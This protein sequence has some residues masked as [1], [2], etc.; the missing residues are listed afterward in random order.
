MVTL[1]LAISLIRRRNKRGDRG[2]GYCWRGELLQANG[3]SRNRCVGLLGRHQFRSL[4]EVIMCCLK[5][6]SGLKARA[7]AAVGLLRR[8]HRVARR[9]SRMVP[10]QFEAAEGNIVEARCEEHVSPLAM[11]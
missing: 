6:A 5:E 11:R 4:C 10:F 3:D 1:L 7:Q 2:S 8:R 9:H